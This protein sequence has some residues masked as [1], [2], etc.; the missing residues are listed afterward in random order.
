MNFCL[1]NWFHL[2]DNETGLPYK[3]T[4]SDAV[5]LPSSFLIDPFR[6]AVV[7]QYN[8]FHWSFGETE[9]DALIVTDGST[10]DFNLPPELY[11]MLKMFGVD[12]SIRDRNY[13]LLIE[14]E[15]YC[16][17]RLPKVTY[18]ELSP[19]LNLA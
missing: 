13:L 11:N 2:Y 4:S 3:G 10:N 19:M 9:E 6:D 8:L 15:K 14:T 5:S 7:M 17:L 1:K 16:L 18:I 12:F